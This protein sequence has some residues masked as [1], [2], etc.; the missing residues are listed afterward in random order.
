[1]T[2]TAKQV[3]LGV[4]LYAEGDWDKMYE[5]FKTKKD[6]SDYVKTHISKINKLAEITTTITSSDYPK[7][8]LDLSKPPIVIL[9]STAIAINGEN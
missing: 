7:Q 3:L 2:F 4:Y 6:V 8:L 1:M 9:K 5:I